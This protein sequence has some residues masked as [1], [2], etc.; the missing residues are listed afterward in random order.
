[1]SAV[2]AAYA[3]RSLG[4]D[5]ARFAREVTAAARPQLRSGQGLLVRR[6]QAGDVRGLGRPGSG[7]GAVEPVGHRAL[8]RDRHE[9]AVGP[10]RRTVR[11]NLRSLSAAV[12]GSSC[13]VALP[14][15]RSKVAYSPSEMS[16]YFAL[17]DAQGTL[18]RRHRASG[19]LCLGAG[20]GLMGADLPRSAAATSS[21]DP[22]GSSSSSA[23]RARVVPVLSTYRACAP[24]PPL[25]L[26]A[27]SSAGAGAAAQRDDA[28]RGQPGRAQRSPP[29]RHRA[30]R[31]TWLVAAVEAIGLKAFMDAAGITCTQRLGDL[32][33]GMTSPSEAEA[34][35]APRRTARRTVGST[36]PKR[37]STPR[38]WPNG[39][40]PRSPSGCGLAAER[41]HAGARH[42]GRA[43]RRAP[44][45]SHQ[46]ARGAGEPRSERSPPPGRGRRVEVRSPCLTYRQI[47]R[48]FSLV[49]RVL[50]KA[51]PDGT[52]A[53]TLQEMVDL[54]Q[55]GL[56]ERHLPR[57]LEQLRRGL[58]RPRDLRAP[59]RQQRDRQG[60][61]P[62][63]LGPSPRATV[64][65]NTTKLFFGYYLSCR[66]HGRRTRPRRR[67]PSCV[68]GLTAHL[69]P[70]RPGARRGAGH[71]A[72][73]GTGRPAS[74]TCSATR[75][76]PIAG[77]STGPCRC[78]RSGPSWS[79]TC[80]PM[81]AAPAA[82]IEGAVSLQR[83]PLLPAR[84]HRR[85]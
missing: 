64:P 27:T 48:T 49:T 71:R 55:R 73:G 1:M 20:A 79:W 54:A 17:A 67:C 50:R 76:T 16:A 36:K 80:T 75:A 6:G 10:S 44:G 29:A 32:V 18:A 83:E 46:G 51:G 31:A 60:E 15:R 14:R 30:P 65:D 41:A 39:S 47:E 34:V 35:T 33:A 62:S 7:R 52:P 43:R 63:L 42:R 9:G 53:A 77:P 26:I 57:G 37:S 78:A 22:V 82:P 28:P 45:A 74:A 25:V 40:R 59:R 84:P 58:N 4:P 3:P 66:H 61:T 38:G 85:S 72:P 2:I 56:G 81:T 11:S 24:Q 5:V 19:L 69:V 8:H 12:I 23:G 68:A 21:P 13:A 70:R